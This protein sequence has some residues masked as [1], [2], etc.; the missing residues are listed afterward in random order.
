MILLQL[1]FNIITIIKPYT[2]LNIFISIE[3]N[4]QLFN[5]LNNKLKQYNN[6]FTTYSNRTFLFVLSLFT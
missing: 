2:H 6:K 1:L 5:F 3:I 4:F